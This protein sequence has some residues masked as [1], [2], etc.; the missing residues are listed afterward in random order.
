MLTEIRAYAIGNTYLRRFSQPKQAY[1]V[2]SEL[3][4]QPLRSTGKHAALAK[5]I[6][7]EW[8]PVV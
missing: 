1:T 3:I 2:V 8:C 5:E 7:L 4:R 6:L